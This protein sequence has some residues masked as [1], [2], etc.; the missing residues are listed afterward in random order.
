M[1]VLFLSDSILFSLH[2]FFC[3]SEHFV[4]NQKPI[5]I[6]TIS[7]IVI[8]SITSSSVHFKDL[9]LNSLGAVH[10]QRDF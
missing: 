5:L 7:V 1:A 8:I 6:I 9:C 4:S 3:N 2:P 10:G